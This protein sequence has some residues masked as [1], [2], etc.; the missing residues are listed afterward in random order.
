[1]N[2]YLLG[3]I[4][5]FALAG[6]L[7]ADFAWPSLAQEIPAAAPAAEATTTNS[8]PEAAAIETSDEAIE[9]IETPAQNM[10]GSVEAATNEPAAEASDMALPAH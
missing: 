2:Y 1:M 6:L 8:V 5:A 7:V 3:A 4:S 9:D 10:Q